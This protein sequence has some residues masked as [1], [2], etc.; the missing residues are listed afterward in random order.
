MTALYV[1]AFLSSLGFS[2]VLPFMVPL[3]LRLGGNAFV[4]G[5]IGALF[6]SAQLVGSTWLGTLSDRIGRKRVLFRSQLGAMAAWLVFL[7]A[8]D[9][10]RIELLHVDRA[11]L[12]TFVI[13]LPL[14]LIALA[15]FTDGLFNGSISVASAY[16]ADFSD[17]DKRKLYYGRLGAASSLGFVVGPMLAGF[18]A[19]GG[20]DVGAVVVLAFVL[21][22][23]AALLIRFRLPALSPRPGAALEVARQGGV[24]AHKPLGGGCSEA[25][26]QPRWRVRAILSIPEV[27]PLIGLYFL[28]Y[29]AFSMFAA[30]MPIHAVVDIQWSTAELGLFYTTLALAL[31]GTELLVLPPLA[32]RLSASMIAAGGSALLVVAYLLMGTSDTTALLAGGVLYGVGN[33]LMWPSYLTMLSHSGS[34]EAQ[35]AVQGVGSSTG[36]LASII[37]TITGG[38]LF[39]RAG[40]VTF[41]I[42][43]TMVAI[44]TL[45]FVARAQ[46]RNHRYATSSS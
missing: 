18:S 39:V 4:V 14:V 28:I 15:R 3:V 36:S 45:I 38:V 40:V 31:G 1:V 42:S 26:R 33:G 11:G 27:R 7:C 37:G 9:A 10:P 16:V 17:G 24:R 43:A 19:R 23:I 29:L 46:A 21:A 32:R 6:W 25:V 2:I 34:R 20:L 13:T 12:G 22:A 35:G 8:L 41:Y 30:S 5:A 44:A